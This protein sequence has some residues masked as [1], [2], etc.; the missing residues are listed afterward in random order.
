M[1][2][3]P[4]P[5]TD[6]RASAPLAA[7]GLVL[8]TLALA[9]LASGSPPAD[10][11]AVVQPDAGP[12]PTQV[13]RLLS[14]SPLELNRATEADLQLLPRIGPTLAARIVQDRNDHGCFQDVSDLTRVRGIGP[15]TLHRLAPMLSVAGTSADCEDP[16]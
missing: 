16:R 2:L 10:V 11:P 14:S 3:D 9:G 8:A 6:R 13:R 15:A 12:P 7:L 5:P 1:P 4:A